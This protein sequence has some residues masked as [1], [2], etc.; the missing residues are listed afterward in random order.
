MPASTSVPQQQ[1]PPQP[2]PQ[3]VAMSSIGGNRVE[4]FRRSL[5]FSRGGKKK[6]PR[7]WK[8][9]FD[10]ADG[11]VYFFNTV[12]QEHTNEWP[13]PLP[14][15]WRATRD[16]VT[17]DAYFW[18]KRTR[19][20]RWERPELAGTGDGAEALPT[21]TIPIPAES[22][23]DAAGDEEEEAPPPPPGAKSAGAGVP[24]SGARRILSF[25][26]R[27]RKAA[28][29]DVKAGA[30]L[31]AGAPAASA[32]GEGDSTPVYSWDRRK[33]NVADYMF[34]GRSGETLIKVPGS[35]DGQRFIIEE[36]EDCDIWL[37]DWCGAWW[38]GRRFMVSVLVGASGSLDSAARWE[39][40]VSGGGGGVCS[41]RIHAHAGHTS[42]PLLQVLVPAFISSTPSPKVGLRDYRPVPALPH[43]H[44]PV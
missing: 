2:A 43:L 5:S 15:G 7:D 32:S 4:A 18:H 40:S 9:A 23:A 13:Q 28:E 21:R 35:I 41:V 19:E 8:S 38:G 10:P 14:R 44:R 3:R 24:L 34:S 12:T 22:A 33:L 26:R 31:A 39:W 29:T 37:L 6:L 16:A 17:G 20:V 25:G 1:S 11:R 30:A 27:P 42:H 36:C